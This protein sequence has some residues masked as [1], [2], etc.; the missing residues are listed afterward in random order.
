MTAL[1]ATAALTLTLTPSGCSDNTFQIPDEQVKP[2]W[3]EVINPYQR[4]ADLVPNL[5]Q[6]PSGRSWQQR[7]AGQAGGVVR[8]PA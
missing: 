6:F 3:P 4:H 8:S 7:A 5:N 2:S 1:T